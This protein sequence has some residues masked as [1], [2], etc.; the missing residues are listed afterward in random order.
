[1]K[2]ITK[3]Q[4][5]KFESGWNDCPICK[6]KLTYEHGLHK[7]FCKNHYR[8]NFDGPNVWIEQVVLG[9]YKLSRS[10]T[11]RLNGQWVLDDNDGNLGTILPSVSASELSEE[12]IKK[13]MIL[14]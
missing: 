13:W 7:L 8:I 11:D 5:A 9:K 6:N 1:M 12:R 2:Y 3:K 14:L 10:P 4:L